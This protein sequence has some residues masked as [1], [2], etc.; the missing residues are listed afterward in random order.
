MSFLIFFFLILPLAPLVGLAAQSVTYP[1]EVV[2]RRMQTAGVLGD[3]R[4]IKSMYA[5]VSP[6]APSSSS[7]VTA[8]MASESSLLHCRQKL[9]M[10]TVLR[11]IIREQGVRGLFKG[12]SLNYIKGPIAIS[13]SFVSY[14]FFK[15]LFF[16]PD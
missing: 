7:S 14:D 9:N 11:G 3:R 5:V 2:R 8:S 6:A 4:D 1:F 12:L 16:H 13:I 10:I 15:T